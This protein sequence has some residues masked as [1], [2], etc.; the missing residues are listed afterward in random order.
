MNKKNSIFFVLFS[1]FPLVAMKESHESFLKR[2]WLKNKGDIVQFEDIDWKIEKKTV[3]KGA[4]GDE[5]GDRITLLHNTLVCKKIAHQ[6]R[7][8][9][10]R[11]KPLDGKKANLTLQSI[12]QS[13]LLGT[14]CDLAMGTAVLG[15]GGLLYFLGKN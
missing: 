8:I 14:A 11:M 1:F 13:T 10:T 9:F 15:V 2:L 12:S 5:V 4:E 6:D 7:K 3:L